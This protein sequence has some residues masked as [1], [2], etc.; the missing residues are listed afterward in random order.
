MPACIIGFRGGVNKPICSFTATSPEE[1]TRNPAKLLAVGLLPQ[2][3]ARPAQSSNFFEL[4]VV[5]FLDTRK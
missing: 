3:T 2:W 4:P 1:W 5:Q